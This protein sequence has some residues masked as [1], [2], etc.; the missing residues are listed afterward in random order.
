V[1]SVFCCSFARVSMMF[2]KVA[3]CPGNGVGYLARVDEIV[4]RGPEQLPSRSCS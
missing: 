1:T 2:I 3:F 4:K